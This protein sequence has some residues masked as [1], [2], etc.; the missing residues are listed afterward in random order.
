MAA[1]EPI[2]TSDN[3]TRTN[4][5]ILGDDV[6]T[7]TYWGH[8]T[9]DHS[10]PEE[11]KAEEDAWDTQLATDVVGQTVLVSGSGLHGPSRMYKFVARWIAKQVME[12]PRFSRVDWST[13][14]DDLQDVREELEKH[15]ANVVIGDRYTNALVSKDTGVMLL[16]REPFFTI[17]RGPVDVVIRDASQRMYGQSAHARIERPYLQPRRAAVCRD[18]DPF[19]IPDLA[20]LCAEYVS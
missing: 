3:E 17:F 7:K 13:L 1:E 5:L 16:S 15:G 19:L 11:R 10:T 6:A 8:F 9:M 2:T 20:R 4:V 12:L 18:L 14:T